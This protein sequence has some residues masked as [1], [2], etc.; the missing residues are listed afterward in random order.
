MPKVRPHQRP[1]HVE[2]ATP[3][4]EGPG[5][6]ALPRR[7]RA[8]LTSHSPMH[9]RGVGE[10][11]SPQQLSTLQPPGPP[12]GSLPAA[13][14]QMPSV[15]QVAWSV[16]PTNELH[17]IPA[18][19]APQATQTPPTQTGVLTGQTVHGSPPVPQTW[20]VL[21]GWQV[22]VP[23]QQP[24]QPRAHGEGGGWH[25]PQIQTP[26]AHSLSLQQSGVPPGSSDGAGAIATAQRGARWGGGPADHPVV[27]PLTRALGGAGL[28]GPTTTTG[29][30]TRPAGLVAGPGSADPRLAGAG[31]AAAVGT[32]LGSADALPLMADG[33]GRAG[34]LADPRLE[35]AGAAAAVGTALGRADAQPA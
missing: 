32:A 19:P 12:P 25:V 29:R 27:Y 33:P 17:G 28:A 6:R 15:L 7:I 31:A 24:V 1:G 35:G 23:S 16:P 5:N 10:Q 4:G 34:G 13:T 14:Q 21:P 20:K 9:R 26:Y 22:P 3:L 30:P 8:C 18:L 11:L 2:S